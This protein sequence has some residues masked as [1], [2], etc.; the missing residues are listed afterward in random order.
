MRAQPSERQLFLNSLGRQLVFQLG[1]LLLLGY[2]VKIHQIDVFDQTVFG[3]PLTDMSLIF[4][5]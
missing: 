3:E 1:K 4:N 5:A 2:F